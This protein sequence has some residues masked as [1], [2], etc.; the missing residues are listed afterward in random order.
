MI[1]L[2]IP[3][4]IRTLGAT[5]TVEGELPAFRHGVVY[6]AWN[7]GGGDSF[8]GGTGAL[9]GPPWDAGQSYSVDDVVEKGGLVFLANGSI[10]AGEDPFLGEEAGGQTG[11]TVVGSTPFGARQ[12]FIASTVATC[13]GVSVYGFDAVNGFGL[14]HGLR[15]ALTDGTGSGATLNYDYF[16]RLTEG[17]FQGADL[18]DGWGHIQFAHPIKLA[19]ATPYEVLVDGNN[20]ANPSKIIGSATGSIVVTSPV[21][22]VG[23]FLGGSSYGGDISGTNSAA[24]MLFKLW[25][26]PWDLQA[27]GVPAVVRDPRFLVYV[28]PSGID[29]DSISDDMMTVVSLADVTYVAPSSFG[30]TGPSVA[31]H[32]FRVKDIIP[33]TPANFQSLYIRYAP[34]NI[35]VD[36]PNGVAVYNVTAEPYTPSYGLGPHS[37]SARFY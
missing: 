3:V 23:T 24:R 16:N 29:F 12:P 25:T 22:S 13:T 35:P 33:A 1:E 2:K 7:A 8:W 9:E 32:C 5:V 34:T 19:T 31:R 20:S 4:P 37:T 11:T 18:T 30:G 14:K 27:A 36:A 21:G 26:T 15:V 17:T 28:G 10:A 6:P